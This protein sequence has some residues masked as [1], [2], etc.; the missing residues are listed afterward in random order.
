MTDLIEPL[1]A[2]KSG[3]KDKVKETTTEYFE[4]LTNKS[5]VDVEANKKTCSEYYKTLNAKKRL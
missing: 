5:G 3:L 4:E 2:Y 1:V